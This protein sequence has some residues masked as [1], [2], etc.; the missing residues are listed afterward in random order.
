M[1]GVIGLAA[2]PLIAAAC[3]ENPPGE[4]DNS[5]WVAGRV[6]YLRCKTQAPRA[7]SPIPKRVGTPRAAP[8]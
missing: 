2:L 6:V 4:F 3:M 8:E 5:G 1:R 7:V